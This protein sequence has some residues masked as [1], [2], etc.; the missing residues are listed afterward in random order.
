MVT[1]QLQQLSVTSYSTFDQNRMLAEAEHA[2]AYSAY[3]NLN[4]GLQLIGLS[5]N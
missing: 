2:N 4:P 5:R 1:T 3:A